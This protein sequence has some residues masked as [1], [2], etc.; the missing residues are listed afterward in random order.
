MPS[1]NKRTLVFI[2]AGN[3]ATALIKGL[4]TEG[5]PASSII[6]TDPDEVKR[7]SLAASL[8]IRT[9]NDNPGT[10]AEADVLILAVKPQLMRQVLKE[11]AS[12]IRGR[13]PLLISIAAGIR[14]Q[15]I[16]RWIDDKDN[17]VAIIRTMP[18]T[19]AMIQAGATGLY[20]NQAV[21]DEQ[22]S[23]A[24][25]VMRAVGLTRWVEDETEIDAVTA[26]SGSGP[27]YFFLMMEVMEQAAQSL[28]L[29]Q[30][31]A[32][33]LT[34][35]TALG[36]ARMAIEADDDPATLRAKVTSP[37]GTTE[38]AIMALQEGGFEQLVTKAIKAA[39]DQSILLSDTLGQD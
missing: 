21:T 29:S 5:T 1:Q 33:L 15:N 24:E 25:R 39:F 12:S 10:V 31:N 30:E 13:K 35:Q 14:T 32:H 17:N 22:R 18:N 6:A 23:Q 27:A 37:G 36:A 9:S 11:I 38:Q 16:N 4:I 3:M 26:L 28:G 20:A 8:G 7:E 19:P 34:L 2:G